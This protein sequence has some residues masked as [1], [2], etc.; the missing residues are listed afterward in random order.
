MEIHVVVLARRDA[1]ELSLLHTR[2]AAGACP[3]ITSG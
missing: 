1:T 3:L 2:G